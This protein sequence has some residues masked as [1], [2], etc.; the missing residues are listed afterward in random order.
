MKTKRFGKVYALEFRVNSKKPQN[1]VSVCLDD[2]DD[3]CFGVWLSLRE[4]KKLSE[5]L[6][7]AIAHVEH[8]L[9]GA[10]E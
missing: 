9:A 4:A 3:P 2:D 1:G 10:R 7:K 6:T 8:Y 5:N